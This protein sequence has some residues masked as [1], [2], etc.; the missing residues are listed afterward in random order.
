MRDIDELEKVQ[1]RSTKLVGEISKLPYE[2]RLQILQLPLLYARHLLGDLT[3][4]FKILKGFN[5]LISILTY[6]LGGLPTVVQE[7]TTSN[8][9]IKNSEQTHIRTFFLIK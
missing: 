8:Y 6:C 7:D 4:T 5:L 3:E 1:H 9:T 2:D